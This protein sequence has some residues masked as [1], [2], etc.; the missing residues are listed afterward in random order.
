MSTRVDD[1]NCLIQY[2]AK[3]DLPALTPDALLKQRGTAQVDLLI[4]MGG[5]TTAVFA[6]TA[7]DA[8]HA[9]LAKQFMIVG[10]D[11]HS[12]KNLRRNV[13]THPVY[14]SVP[15][16]GRPE[17]DILCDIAV[18][19]F[20]MERDQIFIE[21]RSTNCGNNA[22]YAL[23]V[24]RD[25]SFSAESALI[26]Q[27]PMMQRRTVES[28][29]HEWKKENTAF[30]AYA[31]VIPLLEEGPNGFSFSNP[32]HETYYEISAFL[33]LLMGEIPRLRDDADGYGPNGHGF[34]NHVDIP[35]EVLSA[36]NR[37]TN[38]FSKHIRPKHQDKTDQI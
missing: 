2:L 20:S 15:T 37:L 21:N 35:D 25:R 1:L 17:A 9:G 18:E 38:T 10:G 26:I 33:D 3:R 36:F 14:G 23:D 24:I 11:G 16:D 6:K 27:D 34:I 30:H 29:N 13:M 22:T 5:I 28:F 31:P 4:L 32:D 8:F 12:T 7:A 19:F